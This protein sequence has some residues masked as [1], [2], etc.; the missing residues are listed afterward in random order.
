[1]KTHKITFADKKLESAF[2]GL[3]DKDPTK[4]GLIKAIR[5]IKNNFR[6]GRLITRDTHNKIK[7]RNLLSKHK[8]SNIRV[9]NLPT[10][11]R[12]L[13]SITP[14]EDIKIMA[15]ILDWM[16]HKDYEKLLR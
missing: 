4:K 6:V 1:M 15:V 9:Y 16:S 11:W 8:T 7:I 3:S 13:Y 5:D 12:M 2:N 14:S 10:A